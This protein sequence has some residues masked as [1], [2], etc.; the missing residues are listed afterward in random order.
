[1]Q[2]AQVKI[3]FLQKHK[4]K[5]IVIIVIIVIVVVTTIIIT[6]NTTVQPILTNQMRPT[7]MTPVIQAQAQQRSQ[8]QAQQPAQQP[9]Q[10]RSQA[11]AQQPAQQP[12]QQPAQQPTQQ[13]AQQRSQAPAQQPAQQPASSLYKFTSHT[14]TTGGATGR[15]GPVLGQ[16]RSAY[17][18]V[19]WAQNSEFLN[20]TI[21]GIQEWKVPV[22][23]SYSII[24]R[25]ASGGN[26][27]TYGRGRVMRTENV[28]LTKGEILKILV[29]QQGIKSERSSNGGGGGGTFVVRYT[30]TPIIVAGGGG[31]RA[32]TPN[33]EYQ[34]S[35]AAGWSTEFPGNTGGNG[36]GSNNGKGGTNGNGGNGS[37]HH[38]GG[39]GGL[40][41]NGGNSSAGGISFGGLSF[42]NGGI[43]G[44]EQNYNSAY[45][46]GGG[47]GGGGGGGYSGGGGGY[48]PTW[49]SGGGG[50]SYIIP[51]LSSDDN[52]TNIGDG[53]VTI[54]LK[55]IT[56][57]EP[58]IIIYSEPEFKGKSLF[59]KPG[60]Y[61]KNFFNTNWSNLGIGSYK[62]INN[63]PYM[64]GFGFTGSSGAGG[65]S[66]ITTINNWSK[67][68][69]NNY[70]TTIFDGIISFEIFT[71]DE[72]KKYWCKQTGQKRYNSNWPDIYPDSDCN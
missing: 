33:N 65:S 70:T 51:S 54:T 40:L 61:D 23:G 66:V 37:L 27:G 56:T 41:G 28:T 10:Q 24:A 44:L 68:F 13:P 43:G 35:N 39:G 48:E 26:P 29:G 57:E 11:Q 71:P 62:N 18:G 17:S 14:F 9:A 16:V 31:G 49:A 5:I 19:S 60:S 4:I 69:G 6:Q 63:S 45:G 25:G 36:S 32:E 42:V 15:L 20:M 12:T 58:G 3:N 72:Y 22:T 47:A 8:A 2:E 46:G 59:L 21:Q 7:T 53:S 64:I 50:N 55:T 1:M 67:I 52:A 30:Q 38:G 34:N